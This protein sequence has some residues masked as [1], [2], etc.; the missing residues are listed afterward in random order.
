MD[1]TFG[2]LRPH[3]RPALKDLLAYSFILTTEQV[4]NWIDEVPP[5]WLIAGY[6]GD[7]LLTAAI[8]EPKRLTG[9]SPAAVGAIG[10]VATAPC[11]RGRG[12]A[13]EL[14]QYA[15]DHLRTQQV[16]WAI[17]H[18]FDFSFYRRLGWGQGTPMVKITLRQPGFLR[19]PVTSGSCRMAGV[20]SWKTLDEIQRAWAAQGPG[21]LARIERD[22]RRL[23]DRPLRPRRCAIWG[24]DGAGY[25]IFDLAR[26][27]LDS[28][29]GGTCTVHDWAWTTACARDALLAFLANHAGQVGKIELKVAVDDPLTNLEG[30]GVEKSTI[31]GPMVRLVDLGL[32][33]TQPHAPSAEGVSLAIRDAL[34][35]W[36]AGPF[37]LAVR[38][39]G[40]GASPGAGMP[41]AEL[42]IADLSSLVWGSLSSTTARRS[43]AVVGER[44]AA[45]ETLSPGLPAE[46]PFFLDWF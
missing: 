25:V 3:D 16:M 21:A 26:S 14:M 37:W 32:L 45:L 5:G 33:A 31:R 12:L 36:N 4:D 42:D 20:D 28:R 10:G 35:Q 13:R 38:E 22:W 40:I 8:V 34:C 43:G 6:E 46:P 30:E 15:L 7:E 17:L 23:L 19:R 44:G 29:M 27:P 1:V 2:P 41:Q 39:R 24:G 18:P 9:P 11:A